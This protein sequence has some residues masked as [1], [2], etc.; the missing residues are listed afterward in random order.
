MTEETPARDTIEGNDT[1]STAL[2]PTKG[3]ALAPVDQLTPVDTPQTPTNELQAPNEVNERLPDPSDSKAMAEW[4]F[5]PFHRLPTLTPDLAQAIFADIHAG[6]SP[7]LACDRHGVPDITASTWTARGKAAITEAAERGT[8]PTGNAVLYA[9]WAL[10]MKRIR[11]DRAAQ[12]LELLKSSKAA[13]WQRYGWLLERVERVDYSRTQNVN[14]T[15]SV[16]LHPDTP[17]RS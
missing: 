15:G 7:R 14:V 10:A 5:Q 8:Q 1:K 12:W 16:G 11:G 3:T 17:E 6:L 4:I 2:E 13:T 9:N